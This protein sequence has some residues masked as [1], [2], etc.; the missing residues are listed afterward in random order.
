[1]CVIAV[2]RTGLGKVKSMACWIQRR[3]V[4]GTLS[5][6][7]LRMTLAVERVMCAHVL[8]VVC[9]SIRGARDQ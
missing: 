6:F 2:L 7:I 5:N 4:P 9:N 1:M 8:F 3:T